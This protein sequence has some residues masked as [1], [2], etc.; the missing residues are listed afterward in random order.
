MAGCDRG[1]FFAWP[2]ISDVLEH[3]GIPAVRTGGRWVPFRCP[4]PSH[5]GEDKRPSA[6][7]RPDK[8]YFNCFV[9]GER[10]SGLTFIRL[11]EGLSDWKAAEAYWASVSGESRTGS[12]AGVTAASADPFA[13]W[14]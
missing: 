14:G 8:S 9:C 1:E 11:M 3:Y 13:D 4:L 10:G 6:A 12:T 5:P 2:P 7:Y